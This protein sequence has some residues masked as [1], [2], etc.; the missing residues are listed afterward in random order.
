MINFMDTRQGTHTGHV[1]S[2]RDDSNAED[3][4]AIDEGCHKQIGVG[5]SEDHH[6]RRKGENEMF[7]T[8]RNR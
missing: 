6:L 5:P 3:T 4:H 2:Q 1:S 8:G 7:E